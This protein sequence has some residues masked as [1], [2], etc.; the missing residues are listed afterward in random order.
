[1]AGRKLHARGAHERRLK[2]AELDDILAGKAD[3]SALTLKEQLALVSR[4]HVHA[5]R[6]KH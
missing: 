4:A 1:M 2:A 6:R 5:R 3:R